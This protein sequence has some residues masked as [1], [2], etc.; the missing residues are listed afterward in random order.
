[1]VTVSRLKHG[2]TEDTIAKL[3]ETT[4]ERNNQKQKI[5]RD[6]ESIDTLKEINRTIKTIKEQN[7]EI[8]GDEF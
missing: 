5:V 3:V 1:M 4:I 6:A 7:D 2:L 8:I